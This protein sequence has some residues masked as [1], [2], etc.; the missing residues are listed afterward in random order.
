[1]EISPTN[2]MRG[3]TP[4]CATN[5]SLRRAERT[6]PR[7]PIARCLRAAALG[8]T[9][10]FFCLPVAFAKT[11]PTAVIEVTPAA[12]SVFGTP[13]TFYGIVSSP[14]QGGPVPT[15]TITF[16]FRDSSNNNHDIC[17]VTIDTNSTLQSCAYPA[18]F[19][20]PAGTDRF[21]LIYS[22]DSNYDG[23]ATGTLAKEDYVITKADVQFVVVP[24]PPIFVGQYAVFDF[25]ATGGSAALTGTVNIELTGGDLCILNLGSGSGEICA[26]E[27]KE[28]FSGVL[29]SYFSYA[30]DDNHNPAAFDG[31]DLTVYPAPTSLS[32]VPAPA[33]IALGASTMVTAT[34][35]SIIDPTA[36][37]FGTITVG[38][39][40]VSCTITLS[41]D[42]CTLT[43]TSAG[44]R[45]LTAT[46]SGSEFSAPSQATTDVTVTGTAVNGVCGSDN[47]QTLSTTPTNLCNAGTA[48]ALTGSGPWSWTCAGSNNGTTAN[49]SAQLQT[50]AATVTALLLSPNHALVGETVRADVTISGTPPAH[51]GSGAIAAARVAAA[52]G[53]ATVSGGGATCTATITNGSGNCSL[54]FGVPGTDTIT[55]SYAG[56]AANAPSSGNAT[57][58]VNAAVGAGAV[59]SAP[60]LDRWA[61][62]LLVSGVAAFTMRRISHRR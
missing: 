11:T 36:Q 56:D 14:T 49:C 42:N 32:I 2:A 10:W 59:A 48:S 53:I 50:K 19:Y 20:P 7:G 45:H 39:G 3:S 15:G 37:L 54:I 13:L 16:A 43:P 41:N 26:V 17:T 33:T 21:I 18:G 38:D 30:G 8:L 28:K 27:S 12:G 61:L 52:G 6:L 51:A 40:E 1:M 58:V 57:E 60:A 5:R 44:L 62:W 4:D 34:I 47:G 24:P 9:I 23:D 55:A 29:N 31:P 35:A 46:Y 25:Y 22:G